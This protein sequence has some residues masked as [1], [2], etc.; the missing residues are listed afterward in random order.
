[1][2]QARLQLSMSVAA[3]LDLA[4][5]EIEV[6]EAPGAVAE[7]RQLHPATGATMVGVR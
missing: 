3:L 1:M 5:V 2:L 7:H 6:L 4:V